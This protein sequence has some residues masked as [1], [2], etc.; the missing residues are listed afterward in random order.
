MNNECKTGLSR[1]SFMRTLGAASVAAT[2]F[3]AFAAMQQAP[4][5]AAAPQRRRGAAAGGDVDMGERVTDP[6]AVVI[7]SNENPLGMSTSAL[8]AISKLGNGNGRY[9]QELKSETVKVFSEQFGLKVPSGGGGMRGGDAGYV[10]YFPGSGG[11][12]DL[13][14]YSNIG[15]DKPLVMANPSYEQGERAAAAMKAPLFRVPLAADGSHDL[16]AMLAAHP[17]PGAYY[18]VNPNNPTGT[19]TPK[20][21]IVW[22]VKNKPAGSVV[23]IDEAYHHFSPDESS[24][25]LVAAD[26]DV[27]VMRTFSKIYGMAGMRAGFL[28]AKPELQAKLRTL[29]VGVTSNGSGVVSIATAVASTASLQDKTLIPTRRK[30]NKDVRENVL[31]WMDKNGY[32]YLKGSQA[33]FFMVDVKRPGREF[34]TAMAAEHIRIGRTWP[35]MPNW[36]RITVGTQEE[37]DKFKVAFKKCYEAAPL[38]ASAYL[39]VPAVENPSELMRHLA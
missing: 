16:K 29:G 12:L 6:L 28:I 8:E 14:L 33:N 2:S 38:P 11:P 18:I 3:P 34:S 19:M 5:A 35:A 37:M 30:I 7:S 32:S 31:E 22:L 10:S 9:H 1:R 13:A 36:P 26:Q 4:A 17:A 20:S 25:D 23:I 39:D 24:I 15:P 27:I 21:E